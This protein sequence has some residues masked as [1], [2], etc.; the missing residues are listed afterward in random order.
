M[1]PAHLLRTISA[2]ALA[3]AVGL[4]AAQADIYTWVDKSG[5]INVSNLPPPDDV[6]V[7]KVLHEAPKPPP[8]RDAADDPPAPTDVQVLAERVRQLEQEVD[9]ARRQGPPPPMAYPVVQAPP[10]VQYPPSVQYQVVEMPQPQYASYAP[11]PANYGW[12]SGWNSGCD[13]TSWDCGNWWA[14]GFYW[15][16]VIVVS[17]PNFHRPFAPRGKPGGGIPRPMPVP[18][19]MQRR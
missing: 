14:P 1:M 19:S 9:L 10:V 8:V 6:Q 4:P 5:S 12:N 2:S 18:G 13:P 3:L 11:A 15:P 17:A 7:T 16:P